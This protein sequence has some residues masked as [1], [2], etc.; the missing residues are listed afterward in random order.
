MI[1]IRTN[2]A[3]GL[4]IFSDCILVLTVL[5]SPAFSLEIAL[6]VH[7]NYT[8]ENCTLLVE[9][10]DSQAA[11]VWIL[12]QDGQEPPLSK[13]L[14]INDTLTCGKLTLVV[15]R[16]YAGEVADLVC[17]KINSTEQDAQN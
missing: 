14:G 17:L 8:L 3:M 2:E 16:I 7:E 15:K 1:N 9:D 5:T 13:V 12:M 4:S 10:I 11:K 6:S